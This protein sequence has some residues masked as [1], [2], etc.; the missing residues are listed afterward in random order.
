MREECLQ[1]RLGLRAGLLERLLQSGQDLLAA[2][3]EWVSGVW[4]VPGQEEGLLAGEWAQGLLAEWR[5]FDLGL[6]GE[7]AIESFVGTWEVVAGAASQSDRH[8]GRIPR[9]KGDWD[10]LGVCALRVVEFLGDYVAFP[11]DAPAFSGC[12]VAIEA[13]KVSFGAGYEDEFRFP[14]LLFAPTRPAF[15]RRF[16]ILVDFAIDAAGS[17]LI[18]QREDA[19]HVIAGVVAVA[20]EDFGRHFRPRIDYMGL[21][22]W[23][24]F[25]R[26]KRG[27]RIQTGCRMCVFF[28][29]FFV[30]WETM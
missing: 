1:C 9:G 26:G 18:G 8:G 6:A 11:G 28:D 14:S 30:I 3:E 5:G 20:D 25:S 16:R 7:A 17:E 24:Q 12:F 15:G 13:A 27:R 22:V 2:G 23:G 19:I 29:G 4:D 21:C 10:E